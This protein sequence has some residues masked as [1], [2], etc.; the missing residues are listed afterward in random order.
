[1]VLLTISISTVL[2]KNMKQEI[3][4]NKLGIKKTLIYTDEGID[5][6]N[7]N[8][9]ITY[10]DDGLK[11]SYYSYKNNIRHGKYGQWSKKIE[12]MPSGEIKQIHF[13]SQR[14]YYKN[15][16]L[17]GLSKSY[18]SN[19]QVFWNG[20]YKNGNVEGAVIEYHMNGKIHRKLN[21]VNG[22][23]HGVYLSFFKTGSPELE[24]EYYHGIRIGNWKFFNS[25]S[26]I[27]EE[28]KYN[29]GIAW[30]GT[31]TIWDTNR[32]EITCS[33]DLATPVLVYNKGNL[34][35][36]YRDENLDIKFCN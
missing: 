19:G 4:R 21:Y 12:I 25:D 8:K 20:S 10:F 1:M 35:K 5:G 16:K 6:I 18:Y 36:A 3:V 26:S 23:K 28:I 34:S 32:V 24:G 31:Y 11:Y 22:D 7:I 2:S 17:E 14:G 30:E 13:L 9:K 27:V 29:D 33:G 15:G